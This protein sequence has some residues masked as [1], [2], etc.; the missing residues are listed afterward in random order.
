[1]LELLETVVDSK[2]GTGKAARIPGYRVAGKTGT[3][4]M[5]GRHGYLEHHHIS[6]FVGMAPASNPRLVV[7]VIILN[8]QGKLYYGGDVSAPVFKNIME[9]ALRMLNIPPDD[10]ASLENKA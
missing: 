3:A 2:D 8:P 9:G 5:V 6:S 1:M 10:M 4:K 7:A